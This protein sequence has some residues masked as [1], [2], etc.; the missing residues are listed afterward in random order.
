MRQ[1]FGARDRVFMFEGGSE[2]EDV[3]DGGY[4]EMGDGKQ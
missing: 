1:P 3:A 2:A 4:I